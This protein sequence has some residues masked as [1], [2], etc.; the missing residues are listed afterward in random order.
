MLITQN[1]YIYVV[2]DYFGN[3]MSRVVDD[4]SDNIC[5]YGTDKDNKFQQYDSHEAYYCHEWA[6]KHGFTVASK[7]FEINVE[8]DI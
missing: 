8:V 4:C 7:Q 1:I 3:I 6:E 2:K 5:L